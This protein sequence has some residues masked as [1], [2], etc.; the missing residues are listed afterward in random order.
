MKVVSCSDGNLED[1]AGIVAKTKESLRIGDGYTPDGLRALRLVEDQFLTWRGGHW[2]DS[3]QLVNNFTLF[4][5]GRSGEA[6]CRKLKAALE[7]KYNFAGCKMELVDPGTMIVTAPH[8]F[9]P[10]DLATIAKRKSVIAGV[11]Y[12]DEVKTRRKCVRVVLPGGSDPK[13]ALNSLIDDMQ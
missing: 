7:K 1:L 12:W 4:L 11:A 6:T 8:T 13:R 5:P 3:P 10:Q 2:S 9:M